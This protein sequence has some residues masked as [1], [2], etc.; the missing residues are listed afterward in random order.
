MARE[1]MRRKG[2]SEEEIE[3]KLERMDVQ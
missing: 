2:L 3:G 1:A